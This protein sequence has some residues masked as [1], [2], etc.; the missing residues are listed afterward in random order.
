[1][2]FVKLAKVSDFDAARYKKFK[3]LARNLAIFKEPDGS[4][5]ATEISCKHQNWDLTTGRFDGDIVT[6]PRHQWKYNIKTGQCLTHDGARLRR[7]ALKV[8]GDDIYVSLTP[9]ED[10]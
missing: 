4:F 2:Q 3:L 8:E 5:F 10:S 1:M 9:V 6:C 7:Y